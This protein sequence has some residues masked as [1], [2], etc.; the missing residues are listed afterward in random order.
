[1]GPRAAPQLLVAS[2]R[3][4][5]GF[6]PLRINWRAAGRAERFPCLHA[7]GANQHFNLLAQHI[8]KASPIGSHAAPPPT[9]TDMRH[10]ELRAALLEIREQFV[11]EKTL[12]RIS[13][14]IR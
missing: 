7:E 3:H 4:A 11:V 2:P 6:S 1:M 8:S 10:A 13:A 9:S 5:L 12:R 14:I